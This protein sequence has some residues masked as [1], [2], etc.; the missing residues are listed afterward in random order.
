[1]AEG[2]EFLRIEGFLRAAGADPRDPC[3]RVP[4]GDDATVIAPSAGE[5]LVISSDLCVEGVHFRRAWLDWESVGYRAAAAALSDLAAMAARPIGILVSLALPPELDSGVSDALAAG[6]GACLRR[7][8]ASLLGGDLSASPGPVLLDVVAIGS[9]ARP[10]GR[11]GARPGDELWVTGTLG[12]AGVAT[13]GWER[14]LEPDPRARAAFERPHPRLSEATALAERAVIHAIIDLSDGLASDAAHLAAASGVRL[15]IELAALPL[16]DILLEYADRETAVRLA[17]GGGEDY[18]L[19]I[20][21]PP[22]LRS[23]AAGLGGELGCGLSRVGRVVPG[24]HVAWLEESGR[25]VRIE[26]PGWNH[27]RPRERDG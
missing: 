17:I 16:H 10:I 4:P 5:A 12:G 14:G 27:F 23:V 15:E 20:A 25:E 13:A 24:E 9:A 22:G 2:P 18:E 7:H 3:V 21:A 6:I 1:M 26:V 19:L 11:S 8:D